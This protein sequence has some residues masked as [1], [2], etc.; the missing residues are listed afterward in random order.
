[1]FPEGIEYRF[2]LLGIFPVQ[3][4][5]AK[6]SAVNESERHREILDTLCHIYPEISK[7]FLFVPDHFILPAGD[8]TSWHPGNCRQYLPVLTAYFPPISPSVK[9]AV[10]A[11][12]NARNAQSPWSGKRNNPVSRCGSRVSCAIIACFE[13]IIP[14]DLQYLR[15]QNIAVHPG[16]YGIPAGLT[17]VSPAG[18]SGSRE[19]RTEQPE[20]HFP[21]RN[22]RRFP[23]A[24][25]DAVPPGNRTTEK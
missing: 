1:V 19:P 22:T 25:A 6:T 16:R 23:D 10:S 2:P 21:F 13:D 5:S 24:D 7:I 8:K 3:A 9:A 12:T 17:R 14:P 15:Y 20:E 11:Q 4:I 18:P